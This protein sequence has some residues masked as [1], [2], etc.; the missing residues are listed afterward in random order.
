MYRQVRI[1]QD[2]RTLQRIL[3]RR[4]AEEPLRICELSTLTCGTASSP[5]LA[6]RC[7]Q[8]LAEDESKDSSLTPETLT[9]ISMWMMLCV[10]PTP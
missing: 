9:N 3:W 2:D 4:S 6:T 10:D 8:Q 5:Y 7:L 1:H